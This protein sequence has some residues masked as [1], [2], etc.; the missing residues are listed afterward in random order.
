M[1]KFYGNMSY[2]KALAKAMRYCSYQERCRLDLKNRFKVWKVKES[3][4]DKILDYL[5]AEDFLNETRYVEGFIT[6]KFRVKKW[7]VN[8]IKI[9]LI[10]KQVFDEKS[11]TAVFETVI[12]EADYL[13]TLK[14]LLHQKWSLLEKEDTLKKR[15]KT[16]R[17][18]LSKGYE[19]E[20]VV[21]ELTQL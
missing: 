17:Y 7:G 13:G 1:S 21:K 20:L 12:N 18:L 11:F 8:K 4:G 6:G 14:S 3:E 19:S 9:G 15:D 5:I 2:D 16:Y 10:H